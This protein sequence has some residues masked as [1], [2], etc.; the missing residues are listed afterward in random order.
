[1]CGIAGVISSNKKVSLETLKTMS[2]KIAHRGPDGDGQWLNS[3]GS[4][5][6]SHRRLAIIDLSD[7]GRQPMHYAGERYTIV[8]NGEIY[9]YVELKRNLIRKGYEFKGSS[10]TEVLL[11]LFDEK[12]ENCLADLDGMFA[13]AIWD[14]KEQRLFCARDRFGEKPFYYSIQDGS[15]YFA[16]EM[17]ALWSANVPRSVNNRMLFNYLANDNLTNPGDLAETFFEGIVKLPAAHYFFVSP[18]DVRPQPIGYWDI[19]YRRVNREIGEREAVEEFRRLFET[20]VS[21]RLRADVPVGSSLSGG[22][23]SSLIV[24]TI[25]RLNA[26]KQIR[27]STFSARFPDYAKDEG[28]YMQAVIERTNVE[29]HFVFPDDKGLF[30]DLDRLFYHQEE[31]FGT[32]SIYAQFCVMRLAKENDTIVLLD[33][34]GADELLAGYHTYFADYFR[35]LKIENAELAKTERESYRRLHQPNGNGN[36]R[37]S[38]KDW[39]VKRF[40]APVVTQL[41]KAKQRVQGNF[42]NRDFYRE[43]SDYSFVP[44][45]SQPASLAESLYRSTVRGNLEE[46]LRYADRNSMAHSREVRLPFLNHDLAE[47]LFTLP[48]HFKIRAGITKYIMRRAFADRLPPEIANRQDKIGYEPPQQKWLASPAV[49][50]RVVGARDNLIRAR[51]VKSDSG[52]GKTLP[53]D[54]DSR[55][56][57]KFLMTD[58]LT[59]GD[60]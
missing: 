20:S 56:A 32:A 9:N 43:L 30:D 49:V 53:P 41:R 54:F 19:D 34:Q 50:E 16:S 60:L 45:N 35:Q 10:D 48:A 58:A 39:V 8:F 23:D 7:D 55:L 59:N 6:L 27:Q 2:D 5:G 44:D 51:I 26:E 52:G 57:W 13:F 21:R 42:L 46:L 22:L 15:L 1:M 12:K 36:S 31:P 25:D 18:S 29:P 11:A 40:P 14:E 47:F 33:G 24:C 37:D 3:T 28:K 4:V 38:I 17:K